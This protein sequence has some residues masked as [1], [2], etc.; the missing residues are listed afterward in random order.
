MKKR[1]FSKLLFYTI[2]EKDH[3]LVS[4]SLFFVF[5][6]IS[7]WLNA[8][9][10]IKQSFWHII[11]TLLQNVCGTYNNLN[12]ENVTAKMRGRPIMQAKQKSFSMCVVIVKTVKTNTAT[13][14]TKIT[15]MYF[16][17]MLGRKFHYHNYKGWFCVLLNLFERS[18]EIN[19][20]SDITG[21]HLCGHLL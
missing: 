3:N 13:L 18:S 5:H 21:L 11:T 10:T 8:H 14:K 15:W 17:K 7:F 4:F 2:C 12:Y 1:N 19:V 6:F 20:M 9:A 16:T